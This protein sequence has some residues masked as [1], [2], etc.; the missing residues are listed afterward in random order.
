MVGLSRQGAWTRWEN[1]IKRTISWS[2][3]WHA[4][5]SRLK[6]LLQSVYDILPSPA[7]L[8]TWRKSGIPSCPLF[9]GKGMLKHI[10]SACPKTLGDG[11][12]RWTHDQ[13]L[14]TVADTVDAAIRASNFKLEA[15]PIYNVKASECPPT[16]TLHVKLTLACYLLSET[17]S[18]E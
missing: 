11:R 5:A 9:A 16:T 3:I 13:V 12:Y 8:L 14:T 17:G 2:E 15:K 7:N 10:V 1:F 4:D 18:W 6:F